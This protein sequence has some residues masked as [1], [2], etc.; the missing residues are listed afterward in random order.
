LNEVIG[1]GKKIFLL[2]EMNPKKFSHLFGVF[3][4]FCLI[5]RLSH[6]E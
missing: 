1:L 4:V 3:F 2:I 6:S 5:F